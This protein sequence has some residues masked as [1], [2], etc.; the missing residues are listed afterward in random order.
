MSGKLVFFFPFPLCWLTTTFFKI[1]QRILIALG[2][3]MREMNEKGKKVQS[4]PEIPSKQRPCMYLLR[5][6]SLCT[7]SQ[8]AKK[9]VYTWVK[10]PN[11]G[12][13]FLFSDSISSMA[14]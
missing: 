6:G 11:L 9:A 2:Q 5:R 13:S 10:T 4:V 8:Q 7:D 12:K 1:T 3:G 14:K